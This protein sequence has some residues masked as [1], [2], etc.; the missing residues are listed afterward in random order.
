MEQKLVR[1]GFVVITPTL[2]QGD[3][4]A[5]SVDE[6]GKELMPDVFDTIK[7]AQLEMLDTLEEHIRQFK[8]GEREWENIDF[9]FGGEYIAEYFEYDDGTIC[10]YDLDHGGMNAPIIETTLQEWRANR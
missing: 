6:E 4:M 3:V 8:S 1:Q 5:W 7:D 9:D 2:C 10:V